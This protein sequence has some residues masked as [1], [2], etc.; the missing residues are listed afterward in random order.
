VTDGAAA[1][2]VAEVEANAGAGATAATGAAL[3]CGRPH[4]LQKG[5][6]PVIGCP[7]NWQKDGG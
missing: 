5:E 3:G 7:Q 6:A 1:Y 2:A 4:W